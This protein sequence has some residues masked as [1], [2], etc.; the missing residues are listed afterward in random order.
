MNDAYNNI[1]ELGIDAT[2]KIITQDY[3]WIFREKTKRDIGIDAE[4]ET[5]LEGLLIQIQIKTGLGN[6]KVLKSQND[7]LTYYVDEE[8]YNYWTNLKA[9][10]LF[11]AFIPEKNTTYWQIVVR[12][13]LKKTP[14][15]W[16]LFI[17]Y[18]NQL[19]LAS[20]AQI[21]YYCIKP[22]VQEIHYTP[23][24]ENNSYTFRTDVIN[25]GDLGG[26]N[27]LREIESRQEFAKKAQLLQR[28]IELRK[29]VYDNSN[30]YPCRLEL[31]T[32]YIDLDDHNNATI[33][34]TSLIYSLE[35]SESKDLLAEKVFL[36]WAKYYLDFMTD[37]HRIENTSLILL[38]KVGGVLKK[39]WRVFE[40]SFIEISQKDSLFKMVRYTKNY[41]IIT[42]NEHISTILDNGDFRYQVIFN[43]PSSQDDK[44]F[45]IENCLCEFETGL[46]YNNQYL[47][48]YSTPL[49]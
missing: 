43:T 33:E 39:N 32:V 14:K 26:F 20:K 13:N 41:F 18:A 4:A 17:P 11:V 7:G 34:L 1:E 9:P 6:F 3:K 16:K 42:Q 30:N 29:L 21:L 8:H 46:M 45:K 23:N 12:E 24:I 37:K 2:K 22:E 19:D 47:Q 48:E 31:S 40:Q 49:L 28:V 36:I 15:G 25:V 5:K 10:V 35:K 27:S 44:G 38:A